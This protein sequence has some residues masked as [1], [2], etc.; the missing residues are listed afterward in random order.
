MSKLNCY[1]AFCKVP[2]HVYRKR[3]LSLINYIQGFSLSIVASFLIW[4]Q[5]DPRAL[6]IL[7]LTLMFIE[8]GILIRR[9]LEAPCPHCG[10][11]PYLYLK[12]QKAACDRVKMH[13]EKRQADPD[14]WLGKKPP[15]RF[16]KRSSKDI[17]A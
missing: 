14:V 16:S 1:C 11:D 7:V 10:F 17:T 6:V 15:L 5:I 2:R 13:L 9:R 4:R 3:H 8:I 12:D